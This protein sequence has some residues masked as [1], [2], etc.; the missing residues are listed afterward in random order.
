V[1]GLTPMPGK[2]PSEEVNVN[3]SGG[4]AKQLP[5]LTSREREPV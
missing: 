1:K 2:D 3:S 4:G 5:S